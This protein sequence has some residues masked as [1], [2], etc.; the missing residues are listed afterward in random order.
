MHFIAK[1]WYTVGGSKTILLVSE[2]INLT[3]RRTEHCRYHPQVPG[4]SGPPHRQSVSLLKKRPNL[5][6]IISVTVKP[7][8]TGLLGG[9]DKRPVNRSTGKSG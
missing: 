6:L 3:Y 4:R 8:F 5:F 1:N 2:V 7:R 9:S